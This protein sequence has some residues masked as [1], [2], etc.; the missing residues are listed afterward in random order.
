MVALGLGGGSSGRSEQDKARD[1]QD[2][3]GYAYTVDKFPLAGPFWDRGGPSWIFG[4]RGH[5]GPV[6]AKESHQI[7]KLAKYVVKPFVVGGFLEG[8]GCFLGSLGWWS[9]LW[10][11]GASGTLRGHFR[12]AEDQTKYEGMLSG[13][14]KYI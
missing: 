4:I 6:E 11:W 12:L 7:R 1:D 2:L 14:R 10:S 3:H 13:N 8:P 9:F 5:F